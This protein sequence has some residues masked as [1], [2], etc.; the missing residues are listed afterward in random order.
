MLSIFS[1]ARKIWREIDPNFINSRNL[2]TK[3]SHI[4]LFIKEARE[5]INKVKL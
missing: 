1:K 5:F 2:V 4:K 3:R